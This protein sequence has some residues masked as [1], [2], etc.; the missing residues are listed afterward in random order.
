MTETLHEFV[1]ARGE[2]LR[3]DR[4]A[5][6]IRGVKILGTVSRNHR[7]YPDDTLRRAAALYENTRVNVNHPK[8]SPLQPRDYQDR[9]GVIRNVVVREGV[10][11]FADFHFNP[12]HTLAEQ[13]L[14]DAEH[15][16]ENVG[17]SHNVQAR[18][19][20]V[21]EQIVVEEI[22]RVQSV[23][24]VADPATTRGLFE[25]Q[26]DR[27]TVGE[28]EESSVVTSATANAHSLDELKQHQPAMAEALRAELLEEVRSQVA[29]EV[30]QLREQV[31]RLQGEQKRGRRQTLVR[32]LLRE[33]DLP[34]P[35][36]NRPQAKA[37]LGEQFVETLLTADD[38]VT[39]RSLV[40]QRAALIREAGRRSDATQRGTAA[41]QSRDPFS[42]SAPRSFDTRSF[43][44]AIT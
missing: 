13:L 21:D 1:A 6:T 3:V 17:F 5:G 40:E 25:S 34:D 29:A 7:T 31:E 44:E 22:T 24:L 30:E 37:L 26:A 11:L 36:D 14:W 2:T 43:V 20:R 18:T 12:K 38:E 27:Q 33:F 16:P 41:P 4:Q 15:A 42:A 19:R 8:G 39:I 35:D 10:G 28:L 32:K 23:D 9:I